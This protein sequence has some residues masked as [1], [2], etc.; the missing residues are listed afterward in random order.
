MKANSYS[1]DHL[2]GS[3][4][5]YLDPETYRLTRLPV[6]KATTLIPDAYRSDEFHQLEAQRLWHRSWQ[7]VGYVSQVRE[8]GDVT[9]VSVGNDSLMIARDKTNEIHAFYNVCRHRGV[10]LLSKSTHCSVIRCPYHSWGYSLDGR[11][12]GAPYF[13]GLDVPPQALERF[14]NRAE[15][16]GDFCKEDHGLLPVR[17]DTWGGLLFVNLSGDARPLEEWLGDLPQ[18]FCRYPLDELQLV[19]RKE[20]KIAANWK[21]VAENFMEYYHLPTVH[22][23]LC[24]VSGFDNHHRFQGPGMYTGMCTSP[25]TVDPETVRLD[26]PAFSGLNAT[27]AESVYFIMLFPN[28]ALWVFPNHLLT[29]LFR[30][31]HTAITLEH[32]DML[33]HPSILED[34]DNEEQ[35]DHIMEFW[36]LVNLQDVD[37]VQSVQ[38]GLT[39]SAYQGGRMCYEFEE[40]VHRFQN[41]VIDRMLGIEHIPPGDA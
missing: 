18:R 22:P 1:E 12:L 27:E 36:D 14:R 10:K 35:L 19:R 13:Q 6:D 15:A 3:E 39:S 8:P 29:L 31:E 16:E 11:L 2:N 34:P 20:Y 5:A 30:P 23:E 7:C 38:Q 37:I 21:L 25:L 41:M 24:N 28:I 4:C 9:V 33:V 32:M 26:L 40:P 17:L